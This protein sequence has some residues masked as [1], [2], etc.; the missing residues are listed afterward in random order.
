MVRVK[1]RATD[2]SGIAPQRQ[3]QKA[4]EMIAM[5]P[6]KGRLTLLS[7]KIYNALLYHSQQQHADRLRRNPSEPGAGS[8]S[9]HLA[10]LLADAHYDSKS[11]S[12]FKE[13]IREMQTTLIEWNSNSTSERHWSSSQLLGGVEIH[14]RGAPYPTVLTW[15]Y[16]ERVREHVLEPRRYTKLMLEIGDQIRTL[17]AAVLLDVGLRYLTSP[18]GLS[19]REEVHWWATALTGR[20]DIGEV[21]YRYFKRDVVRPALA[22]I[23]TLQSEFSL[24]LIEHREGRRV[25]EL[26]FQVRRKGRSD[27]GITEPSKVFDLALLDRI[28]ALGVRPQDANTLYAQTDEALLRLTVEAVEERMK[29]KKLKPLDSPA[30]FFRDALRKGY[31]ALL[32]SPVAIDAPAGDPSTATAAVTE[33]K[34]LEIARSQQTV[35]D[36]WARALA[37]EAERAF[38]TLDS[39]RQQA[40]LARFDAEEVPQMM[41]AIARAWR[42]EGIVSRSAKHLFFR[43]IATTPPNVAPDAEQLLEFTLAGNKLP[44]NAFRWP[45]H[46]G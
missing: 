28:H 7:W 10:D 41:E 14:E 37:K 46:P 42:S 9:M 36:D 35:R 19:L 2:A 6:K 26:Q 1:P 17:A 16:P 12:L 5:R 21:D 43:W 33:R 30:A 13:H 38:P 24:E 29:N 23:E 31:A 18:S 44:A 3:V 11:V 15:N 20:S 39:A 32:S 34:P 8:F 45:P 22:E 40:F 25:V 4:N 27:R